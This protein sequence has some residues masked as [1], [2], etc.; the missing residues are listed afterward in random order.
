[1]VEFSLESKKH[2]VKIKKKRLFGGL[3]VVFILPSHI[4][5]L[6]FFFLQLLQIPAPFSKKSLYI[7]PIIVSSPFLS[8]LLYTTYVTVLFLLSKTFRTFKL[9]SSTIPIHIRYRNQSTPQKKNPTYQPLLKDE[10]FCF[11]CSFSCCCHPSF[12]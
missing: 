3:L 1:M 2:Q 5:W 4:F 7:P 6:Y 8:F 9:L 11:C 10:D 12:S